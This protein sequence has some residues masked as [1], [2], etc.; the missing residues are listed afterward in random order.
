[1][2]LPT[3]IVTGGAGNLGAV[4]AKSLVQKGYNVA[5][6]DTDISSRNEILQE[7]FC[8]DVDVTNES[9]VNSAVDKVSGMF[10]DIHL[11]VNCAGSIMSAPLINIT[12]RE[13]PRHG[14][15][16]FKNHIETNLSSVFLV[17]SIVAERMISTRTKGVIVNISSVCACGNKGQSAYSAAK[18]GV[19]ALTKVW[20]KELGAFGIR[21]AAVAPGFI[22]TKSTSS[23]LSEQKLKEIKSAT[24]LRRLGNA[25][26]VAQAICAITENDFITGAIIAVDGGVVL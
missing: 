1:M 20:G 14:F 12:N 16:L 4:I 11:L 9:A 19:E 22:D 15:T 10:G 13:S 24:P 25:E 5:I 7:Y 6:F 8:V 2:A 26:N 23:A 3:A 17:G 18:A 21:V